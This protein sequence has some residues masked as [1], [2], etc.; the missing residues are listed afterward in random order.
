MNHERIRMGMAAWFLGTV[1]PGLHQ[2]LLHWPLAGQPTDNVVTRAGSLF[3]FL[4]WTDHVF[5]LAMAIFGT[6]LVI[7]GMRAKPLNS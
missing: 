5:F 7:S 3:E 1:V 4:P 6:I 2:V